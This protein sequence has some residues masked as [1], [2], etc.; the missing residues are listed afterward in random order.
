MTPNIAA[1]VLTGWLIHLFVDWFLQ[2]D[3]MAKNKMRF[4]RLHNKQGHEYR[5]LW[6]HP[7]GLIHA[8]L[9]FAA[10]LAIFPL[11]AAAIV[12]VTHWL[13]DLRRPLIWWRTAF[14]ITQD[15]ANPASMHVAMWE[16]QIAHWLIIAG[17]AALVS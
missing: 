16:D 8:G 12:G 15:P 2:N 3:F 5:G 1:L 9:H 7:A 6:P 10:M 11:W 14:R 4:I 13:I 17:V